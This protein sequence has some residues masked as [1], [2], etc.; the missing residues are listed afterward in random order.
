MQDK[1]HYLAFGELALHTKLIVDRD[2]PK[3][4]LWSAAWII[5]GAGAGRLGEVRCDRGTFWIAAD[6]EASLAGIDQGEYRS[7][8]EVALAIERRTGGKCLR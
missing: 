5:E 4:S 1:D 2:R 3:S 8:D 7:L 6:Q